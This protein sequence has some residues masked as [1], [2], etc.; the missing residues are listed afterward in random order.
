VLATSASG[1]GSISQTKARKVVHA[2][3]TPP[4]SVSQT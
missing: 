4:Y 2:Q 3:R 1:G